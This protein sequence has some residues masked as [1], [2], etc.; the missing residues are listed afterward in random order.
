[1]RLAFLVLAASLT[2]FCSPTRSNVGGKQL[3]FIADA[4]SIE[5]PYVT[6]GLIA[7]WDGE[8]NIDVGVHD[9]G[10]LYWKNLVTGRHAELKEGNFSFDENSGVFDATG[11]L[12]VHDADYALIM[13]AHNSGNLEIDCIFKCTLDSFVNGVYVAGDSYTLLIGINYYFP[14]YRYSGNQSNIQ[15]NHRGIQ[16]TGGQ[17][18]IPLYGWIKDGVVWHEDKRWGT[19]GSVETKSVMLPSKGYFSI[20]V[21]SGLTKSFVGHIYCIRIYNRALTDEERLFNYEIDKARFGL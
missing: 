16:V 17:E 4:P 14:L 12:Q 7:M 9:S 13:A 21:S 11:R 20:G 2:A 3:Q 5:I 8:W 1:M 18:I 15:G 6:S 19:I 10:I